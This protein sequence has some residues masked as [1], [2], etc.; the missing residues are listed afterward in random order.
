[1]A[2]LLSTMLL[3][4][5]SAQLSEIETA[6]VIDIQYTFDSKKITYSDGTINLIIGKDLYVDSNG[7]ML[8]DAKS[9]KDCEFCDKIN[10]DIEE[11]EKYPI[12]IIDYNYTSMNIC[13]KPDSKQLVASVPLKV[14]DKKSKLE[15]YSKTTDFKSLSDEGCQ[16]IPFGFDKEIHFGENSTLISLRDVDTENLEDTD[17]EEDSASS[18]YGTGTIMYTYDASGGGNEWSLML[19][20]GWGNQIPCGSNVTSATLGLYLETESLDSGEGFDVNLHHI[21]DFPTYAISGVDWIETTATWAERPIGGEYNTT[22]EDKVDVDDGITQ[23]QYYEWDATNPVSNRVAACDDNVSFWLRVTNVAGS[24]TTLDY[25]GWRT[26]EIGG[27]TELPYLNITFSEYSFSYNLTIV[28]TSTTVTPDSVE[29][30]AFNFTKNDVAITTNIIV[31]NVTIDGTLCP[32]LTSCDGSPS[33]CST[34][35]ADESTCDDSGCAWDV[36]GPCSGTPDVCV[37]HV[38]ES[39]CT[40]AGC[41][42]SAGASTYTGWGL[43]EGTETTN[44]ADFNIA[45]FYGIKWSSQAYDDDIF[46][47][48]VG[49]PTNITV[50]ETGN[51]F[52]AVNLPVYDSTYSGANN[53]R[54]AIQTDFRVNGVAEDIG[55][56]T[57]SYMRGEGGTTANNFES[58]NQYAGMISLTAGDMLEVFSGM[59][60]TDGTEVAWTE[61]ASLYIEKIDDAEEIFFGTGTI[62]TGG[63]DLDRGTINTWTYDMEWTEVIEDGNYTHSDASNQHQITIT[64]AGA[65]YVAVNIPQDD[66]TGQR[67]AMALR[68]ELDG[69]EV[70]GTRGMTGYER[71]DDESNDEASLHYSGLI[72]VGAGDVLSVGI[73][74]MSTVYGVSNVIGK[75]TILIWQMESDDTGLFRAPIDGLASG[76]DW[77]PAAAVELTY[78]AA[79]VKDTGTYTHSTDSES[80]MVLS[81]GIYLFGISLPET[82]GGEIRQAPQYELYVNDVEV[83]SARMGNTY[84]RQAGVDETTGG[85]NFALNLST[86][87][88]ITMTVRRSTNSLT[89]ATRSSLS[90]GSIS[91]VYKGDPGPGVAGCSDS[92]DACNTHATESPC[93]GSGCDWDVA[94]CGGTADDCN[95]FTY[96]VNCTTYGCTDNNGIWY[97]SPVWLVNCTTPIGCSGAGNDL[98]IYGNYTTDNVVRND[99]ALGIIDCGGDTCTCA[100]LD[101]NWEI[102]MADTCNIT[103]T[104]NL[105]T[106]LLNFTGVGYVRLNATINASNM[107]DPSNNQIIWIDSNCNLDI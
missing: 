59:E 86:N 95:T 30:F 7:T 56:F 23:D 92:P 43:F 9:L 24:P 15:L 83:P 45:T 107:A 70:S 98:Q 63:T 62:S 61:G 87:D 93:T 41:T 85:G 42:W 90:D 39:P 22:I 44:G 74:P 78:G 34:W 102:D 13:V 96:A 79:T 68:I 10:L 21:Y 67:V 103:N 46:T 77:H 47:W 14:L 64:D 33:A 51:Y 54:M 3:V 99:T 80:I 4:S 48:V 17:I 1:M 20:F 81:D 50:D 88:N 32:L 6:K 12:N 60:G 82:T 73:S 57:T 25:A 37:D 53:N 31:E 100:G 8:E 5:S 94:N 101:T 52:I 28:N 29:T 16:V 36:A 11:D 65:Y 58:S 104:C 75:A 106:G 66:G 26:K 71:Q 49:N 72:D 40:I 35:D 97:V 2:I 89:A 18:N 91:I 27:A 69:A 84:D 76:T 105:G 19:K 38:T 55:K